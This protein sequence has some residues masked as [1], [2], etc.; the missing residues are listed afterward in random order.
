MAGI[1]IGCVVSFGCG[2]LFFCIG[3]Y[4]KNMEKPM[5]FWSGC[6]V[7]ATQLTDAKAYNRENAAMWQ[8]YSLWYFVGGLVNIFSS[9]AYILILIGSCTL[10]LAL[11]VCRYNR[12]FKKYSE[13]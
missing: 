13:K 3:S 4:A 6:E 12:I 2:I 11:L 7:N 8:R 5:W 9:I 10:G 1:I